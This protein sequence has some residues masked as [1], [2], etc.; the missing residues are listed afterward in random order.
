[1]PPDPLETV[2]VYVYYDWSDCYNLC[3][4]RTGTRIAS[5]NPWHMREGYGSSV[6]HGI[7]NIAMHCVEIADNVVFFQKFWQHL[8]VTTA[9]L[10]F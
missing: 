10:A 7:F 9:F 3:T 4:S 1:M 2:V 8:L 6:C 5:I